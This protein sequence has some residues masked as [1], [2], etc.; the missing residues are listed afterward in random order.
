MAPKTKIAALAVGLMFAATACGSSSGAA[1]AGSTVRRTAKDRLAAEI[2]AQSKMSSEPADPADEVCDSMIQKDVAGQLT[3]GHVVGKPVSV[4]SGVLTTCTYHL[5]KGSL[6]M[7][8]QE[9][10]TSAAAHASFEKLRRSAGRTE[11]IANLGSAA[12]TRADMSTVTVKDNKVLIVDTSRLPA[13]NDKHQISQ[14]LS[15]EVLACW[16]G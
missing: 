9:P 12:F 8:V 11:S 4:K 5:D 2:D 7:T 15:F 3:S 10:K 16:A 1:P 14:S 13:G 6:R